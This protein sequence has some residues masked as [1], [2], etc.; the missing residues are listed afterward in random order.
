MELSI[1]SI[2]QI[3]SKFYRQKIKAHRS[4]KGEIKMA[5]V[6]GKNVKCVK[7][8]IKLNGKNLEAIT[9]MENE[10]VHIFKLLD[11]ETRKYR[12]LK[13]KKSI[14]KTEMENTPYQPENEKMDINIINDYIDTFK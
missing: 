12:Y 11:M 6:Y 9:I 7:E 4:I 14:N 1:Y 2:K 8:S 10:N 13:T 5:I 3:K